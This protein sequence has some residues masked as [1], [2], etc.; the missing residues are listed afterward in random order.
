VLGGAPGAGREAIAAAGGE[1]GTR[2]LPARPT[3]RQIEIEND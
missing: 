1:Q 3:A 2:I